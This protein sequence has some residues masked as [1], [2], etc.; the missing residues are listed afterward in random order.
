MIK[1]LLFIF[2]LSTFLISIVSGQTKIDSLKSLLSSSQTNEQ[3]ID[4]Y[5]KLGDEYIYQESNADSS[6]KYSKKAYELVKI[7]KNNHTE[8]LILKNIGIAKIYQQEYDSSLTYFNTA[9]D[10]TSEIDSLKLKSELYNLIGVTYYYTGDFEKTLEYWN[11]ELNLNYEIGN[12][13]NIARNLNNL[14]VI[15]KNMD[16]YEDAIYFYQEALKI[17][18][19][20]KDSSSIARALTN[21]GNIYFHNRGNYS[22]A[23]NYYNKALEIYS[24]LGP[25]EFEADLLNNIGNIYLEQNKNQSALNN[26]NEALVIFKT[27]DKEEKIAETHNHL[28]VVYAK[29]G[30]YQTA[31]DYIQNSYEYYTSIEAKPKIA[32]TLKAQGDIYL[33]WEK[34]QLALRAYN[35]SYEITTELGIKS[36]IA[37]LFH[38]LSETYAKLNNYKNAFDYHVLSTDLNDSLFSEKV[39]RQIAEFQTLYE[40]EKKDKEIS[41]LNKDKALQDATLKRQKLVLYFF[42]IGFGIISI[43]LIFIFRLFKHK[44]KANIILEQKNEEISAQRDHIFQQ[45]KEITDSIEYASRIQTALLPPQEIIDVLIPESFILF[46]PR[47]IVSGDY[48]WLGSKGS[49]IISV[50]ADC[51]GHGVPGA[52][53]SMLGI[54]FLNEIV[55]LTD[56]QELQSNII[57]NEMRSL[58]ISSLRQTGNIGESRDGMDMTL[59]IIDRKKMELD[60]SGAYNPLFIIRNNELIETKGD[61]MPIG[62]HVKKS[63][64]FSNH[65]VKLEKGDIIYTFSDG[66]VDQ[67]GGE[68]N[69]KFRKKNFKD[70]LLEIHKKPMLEQ[71]VILDDTLDRWMMGYDQ[72]DDILVSGIRIT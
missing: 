38:K 63:A 70:L 1:R 35:K 52:F 20:R 21:I 5:F 17:E 68:D 12:K 10:V 65:I 37:E 36:D 13:E 41:L 27:L 54:S 56:E 23:L 19:E 15:H 40:T 7:L 47:D 64:D 61:K 46:R 34:Y 62:I 71:K 49:K 60:F 45:N 4:L 43:L 69:T 11:E 72:V 59:C 55:N 24:V 30:N 9:L 58:V 25:K 51:T 22:Q 39:N 66:Y 50:T 6:I 57:L 42:V 53:M 28:G 3:R 33:E 26:F 16:Q 67:F 48:Y 14:G 31:I 29:L 2:L 18:E 8:A 44:Q 32:E